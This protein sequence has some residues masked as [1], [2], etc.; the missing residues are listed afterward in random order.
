M[1]NKNNEITREDILALVDVKTKVSDISYSDIF[2]TIDKIKPNVTREFW[3][4]FWIPLLLFSVSIAGMLFL[5]PNTAWHRLSIIVYVVSSVGGII[6]FHKFEKNWWWII[7]VEI[8]IVYLIF[9]ETLTMEGLIKL[10]ER[11]I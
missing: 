10:I 1:G 7:L 6:V 9:A 8:L 2:K 5:V 3:K 4:Y 11:V